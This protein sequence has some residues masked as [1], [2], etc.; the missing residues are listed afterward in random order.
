MASV[1]IQRT[2]GGVTETAAQMSNSTWARQVYLPAGWNKIRL[3]IRWHMTSSG[4]D[5]VGGA[6]FVMGFSSGPDYQ[7]GDITTTHFCGIIF[8]DSSTAWTYGIGGSQYQ[9]GAFYAGMPI[10]AIVKVGTSSTL[11]SAYQA[12]GSS[13]FIQ[14]GADANVA[15]RDI[16]LL[17][18]TKGSPNYTF[19]CWTR[20]NAP[21]YGEAD[22][23]SA[24]L[25]LLMTETTPAF[26][27][28]AQGPEAIYNTAASKTLA[29]DEGTN[30]T[31]NAINLAWNHTDAMVEICDVAVSVLS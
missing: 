26:V 27:G 10:Y 19:T 15:D 3:G 7:Y 20:W 4:A 31:L 25:L 24:S 13:T 16:F 21:G 14:A 1:I 23:S 17:D 11:S 5:I 28:M 29:I 9:P 12:P 6:S 18:V 2:I 8:G 30:G 22:W